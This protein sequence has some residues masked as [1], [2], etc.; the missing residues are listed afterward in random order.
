VPSARWRVIRVQDRP[1][2]LA[3]GGRPRGGPERIAAPVSG[4]DTAARRTVIALPD[5]IGF[6]AFERWA[7]PR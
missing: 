7:R 3:F 5:E 1:A 6:A 2:G 4:A